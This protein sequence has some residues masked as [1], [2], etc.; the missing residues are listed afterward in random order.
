MDADLLGD[1]H[2]LHAGAPEGVDLRALRWRQVA[3]VFPHGD[4]SVK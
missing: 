2:D 3:E 4:P 1:V